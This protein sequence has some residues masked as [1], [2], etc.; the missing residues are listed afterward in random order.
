[1]K[2]TINNGHLIDPKNNISEKLNI[3]I[4]NGKIVELS[5]NIL[6]GDKIIDANNLY[7]TPGFIDM[8]MH[9]DKMVDGKI[10]INIFEK[11]LKMG[12]TSAIG[13]NCG[14]GVEN[15]KEYLELVDFGLPINCGMLLPHEILRKHIDIH[16]RYAN[17]DNKNIEKMYHFGKTL[18][19]EN[20]LLGISF[21][22][23]YIPGID[24]NELI[25]L[26]RLGKNRIVSAHLREDG[27]NV[28]KSLEELLEIGKFTDTHL[29]VS[30]IGSMAGYGQMT[31]FLS[32]I[33]N[34]KEQGIKIMCDCY[35]YKA[36][37]TLIG[38]AVFDN[39]YIEHHNFSYEQLQITSGP[40]KGSLCTKEIFEKLRKTAPETLVV[41]HMMIEK[42][43]DIAILN[44]NTIVVSDGIL[45]E[46][47]EGHPRAAGAFPKFLKEYVKEKKL[48]SIEEAIEKITFSPAKILGINKGSLEIGA[49]ADITIFSL[50]E[51]E[52]QANF[53]DT[54]LAPKGIKYVI[55]NG[56]IAL[57]NNEILSFNCGKSIRRFL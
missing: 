49:D 51:I 56:E 18:I 3:G 12:V 2:I 30:H 57:A 53:E 7:V 34:R 32:E 14:I 16:D 29:Q 25:T 40:L 39:N 11:L 47:G 4:E 41:G 15:I 55:V 24:F 54:S 28:L 38:S 19:K 13:G 27:E 45:T 6:I 20:G 5:K 46:A 48:I 26:A 35:P 10:K 31:K 22:I 52:D 42:D 1:M 9:E 44:R 33:E 21:G 8:H 43:I 50:D 36:F 23:E 17:L 37:S